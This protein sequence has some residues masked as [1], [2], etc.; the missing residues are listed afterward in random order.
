V[1]PQLVVLSAPSGG[2]KTT[3]TKE[4][5]ARRHDVGY[6]VSATTRAPRPGERDGEAYHFLTPERFAEL[7][8]QGAFLETAAYA[9]ARYGTLRSEVDKVLASRRH[10][11]LD[12]EIAGAQRVRAL[13]PWPRS[14]EIFVLPP[15]VEVLL[16]R[17]RGRN[18]E[19]GPALAPRVTQA[20]HE[21]AEAQRFDYRIVNDALHDAVA[22]VNDIIDG[23][24][25]REPPT[26]EER[27]FIR[28]LVRG[29]EQF[30]NNAKWA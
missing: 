13:Y 15:S 22:A 19:S 6:S 16:E 14:I 29:L 2:G 20:I 26:A 8:G 5:L 11:V 7:E 18:T 27:R 3:I 30:A 17:L 1:T 4:I 10:V 25:P 21:L 24:R 9:G 23:R 12:I 28:V